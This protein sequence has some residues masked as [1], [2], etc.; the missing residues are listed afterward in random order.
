M[1]KIILFLSI[2]LLFIIGCKPDEVEVKL[3]M[4]GLKNGSK[5]EANFFSVSETIDTINISA[6]TTNNLDEPRETLSILNIPLITGRYVIAQCWLCD[7][8]ATVGKHFTL[9]ECGDVLDGVFDVCETE[10]NFIEITELDKINKYISGNFQITF[11]Q[12]TVS[13]PYKPHL[14]DTIRFTNVVFSLNYGEL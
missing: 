4:S 7:T 1:K 12:D 14:P 2:I 5:W 3:G 8:S 10:N 11:I 13:K 6:M 9:I